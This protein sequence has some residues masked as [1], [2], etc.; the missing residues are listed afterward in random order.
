MKFARIVA[1]A[2]ALPAAL[3]VSPAAG[4][5]VLRGSL[6]LAEKCS[7]AGFMHSKAD[8]CAS[9]NEMAKEHPGVSPCDC[10]VG[11]CTNEMK[12]ANSDCSSLGPYYCAVCAPTVFKTA[13]G[14][15]STVDTAKEQGWSDVG[16]C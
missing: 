12:A 14:E 5:E 9:C 6:N 4:N 2:L 10:Q 1:L 8:A 7:R 13:G 3:A 15:V 16:L 11:D